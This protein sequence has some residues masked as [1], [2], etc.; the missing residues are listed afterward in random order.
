MNSQHVDVPSMIETKIIL[1]C[2][3]DF[4][5][6]IDVASTIQWHLHKSSA[7]L[8]TLCPIPFD[9]LVFLPVLFDLQHSTATVSQSHFFNPLTGVNICKSTNFTVVFIKCGDLAQILRQ[10]DY[11]VVCAPTHLHTEH[12]CRCKTKSANWAPGIPFSPGN[13]MIFFCIRACRRVAWVPAI[14]VNQFIG[15]EK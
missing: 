10:P 6:Q 15:A 12:T 2:A 4:W 8:Q 13:N 14:H 1:L 5:K 7:V 3:D 9:F 11:H